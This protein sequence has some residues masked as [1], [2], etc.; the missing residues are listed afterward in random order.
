M[1]HINNYMFID[2]EEKQRILFGKECKNIGLF[3]DQHPQ[4]Q[5]YYSEYNSEI[6]PH[7]HVIK[8]TPVKRL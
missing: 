4:F 2:D 8:F 7:H 3:K 5:A 6:K 1:I